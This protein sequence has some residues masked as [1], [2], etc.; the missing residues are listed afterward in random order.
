[1][2]SSFGRLIGVLVAPAKTFRSLAERPTWVVA[3]LVVV[4]SPLL[5]GILAVPKIDWE[6][7]AKANLEKMDVQ[8][9]QEQLDK[10]VEL[11]EKVGPVTTY[12]APVFFTIGL[13]LFALVFWG[14]FTLAGGELGFK[15]SLTVVSHGM[16]PVVVSAL[17]SVPVILRLDTI[18]PEVA[19]AGSYLQSNLAFLLP[20][21][22]NPML[23]ALLSK[24][25]VFSLWSLV[26]LVI[27][28]RWCGKVS[29]KASLVTVLLLWMVWVGTN[30]GFAGLGLLLGGRRHG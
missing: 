2:E 10:Q 30:V 21:D 29:L 4:L 11:M 19:Q 20:T 16:L 24:I 26:L 15:R 14:A 18:G 22:A 13:L 3:L 8:V 12:A 1:M 17:L 6:A 25:D 28:F 9:P 5:P 23:T 7:I 27:G